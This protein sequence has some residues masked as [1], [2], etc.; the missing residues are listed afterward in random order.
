MRAAPAASR[1]VFPQ[2]RGCQSRRQAWRDRMK[3]PAPTVS[4]RDSA[5]CNTTSTLPAP[6]PLS[7]AI[8]RPWAV[9]ASWGRV[10]TPRRAGAVPNS[11]A[12]ETATAAVKPR[13]RQS[14]S[15][16]RTTVFVDVESCATTS[17]LPICATAHPRS[18]PST[19]SIMLSVSSWRAMRHRDAPSAA[20]MSSSCRRAIAPATDSRCSRR[21]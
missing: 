11:I 17:R 9:I 2:P 12:V 21:Q 13:I 7:P 5:T 6:K 19:E 8:P 16:G 15:S 4:T 10:R 14:R 18:A 20:R 1:Q 3:R